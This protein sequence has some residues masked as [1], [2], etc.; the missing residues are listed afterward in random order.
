MSI[1][2]PIIGTVDIQA[3]FSGEKDLRRALARH[4]NHKVAVT[5]KRVY[6]M[7][8]N[9]QC[10]AVMGLWGSII[11]EELGYGM[12]QKDAVYNAIKA[13]CFYTE[14]MNKKTGEVLRIGK[15]TKHL[16]A[17]EYSDFMEIFRGFVFDFFG[18]MLPDPEAA[19]AMI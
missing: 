5:V 1:R 10:R 15:P 17:K 14:T 2:L 4:C 11:L 18:I 12:E 13:Q 19:R 7:R 16:D 6:K 3:V 8:S 9:Q